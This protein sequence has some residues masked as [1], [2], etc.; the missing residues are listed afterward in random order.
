ME[1]SSFS[2]NIVVK[3]F[4]RGNQSVELHINIDAVVPAYYEVLDERL[5]PAIKK[6]DALMAEVD[7]MTTSLDGKAKKKTKASG[8]EKPA[9][10]RSMIVIEKEISELQREIWA[11]RLSI[12]VRLPDG[13]ETAL[14]K[15]WDVTDKGQPLRP[16]K[17]VLL[18]M[19]P[20]AVKAIGE[21]CMRQIET[22]KKTLEEE[23]MLE[24]TQDGSPAL[25]VVGQNA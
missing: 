17:D 4:K 1:L 2:E 25:R 20:V 18:K 3:T 12:P 6:L 11:D 15:D 5:A 21:F 24:S 14:L 10:H 23:A 8:E 22:V 16:T 13:S 9:A 19:P 7:Q